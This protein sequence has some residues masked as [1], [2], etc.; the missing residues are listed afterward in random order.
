MGVGFHIE[1][2]NKQEAVKHDPYYKDFQK[3]PLNFGNAHVQGL[4]CGTR[5]FV[6]DP[7]AVAYA[8]SRLSLKGPK[9]PNRG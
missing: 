7:L 4:Y 9:Y 8:L 3:G 2:S 6:S 1:V 5:V